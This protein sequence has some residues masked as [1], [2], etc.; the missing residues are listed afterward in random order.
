MILTLV[1]GTVVGFGDHVLPLVLGGDLAITLAIGLLIAG[2]LASFI[3][4]VPGGGLS[5]AGVGVYWWAT[6]YTEPGSL[7]L[8][9]F[10]LLGVV[11]LLLDWFAGALSA[12]AGGASN[13]T[14]II[15]GVAGFVLLFVAGPV[16]ILLGIA[17]TVFLAELHRHGD[18]SRSVRTAAF[19]TVGML[20][21]T[22]AQVVLTSL[23]LIAFLIVIVG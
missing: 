13:R 18:A 2:V 1:S 3:P 9:G 16:G 8:M 14:M 11:T 15:A 19:A 5:L 23:I 20:A 17:G 10:V 12:R 7:A 6:G 4:V 22:I 21:S